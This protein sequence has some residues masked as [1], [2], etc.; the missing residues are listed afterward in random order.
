MDLTDFI[1]FSFIDVIDILLVAFLLFYLYKLVKGTVAIN[2]FIGIVIIYLIWR[3][4]DL[5]NMDVLSNLLGK[6]ISVGFFALIVVFQQEIRKFLLLLGSNN[7]TTRRNVVRYFK[8]LNQP[9]QTSNLDLNVL[10]DSCEDMAK[11]NTGAIIVLQR[12][13]SLDFT[14]TENNRSSIKLMPQI[15]ESIFFKNSPLHDGAIVIEKNNIIATRV[16]LPVSDNSKM[17]AHYGLR[18]RAAQGISEKTDALVLVISEQTGRIVYVKNGEF[19]S[20]D[21]TGALRDIVAQDLSE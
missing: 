10:F 1:D 2:I 5:L 9:K 8:F 17:P 21:S 4:T 3:L 12:S 7:F 18:H 11:T 6:F 19:F 16:V 15:L 20:F 14:L 13:N